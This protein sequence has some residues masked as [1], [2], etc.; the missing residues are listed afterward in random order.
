MDVQQCSPSPQCLVVQATSPLWCAAKS[1]ESACQF[2]IAPLGHI[3]S[4]PQRR[5]RASALPLEELTGVCELPEHRS[6][7]HTPDLMPILATAHLIY[8]EAHQPEPHDSPFPTEIPICP[9]S[10]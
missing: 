3:P 6:S 5:D 7:P 4:A 1:S 8:F 2:M 10:P 9:S